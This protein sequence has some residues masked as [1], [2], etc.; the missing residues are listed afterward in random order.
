MLIMGNDD[1]TPNYSFF[2]CPGCE[3][4]IEYG[5]NDDIPVMCSHCRIL[6]PDMKDVAKSPQTRKI[7]HLDSKGEFF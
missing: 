5:I 4:R 2:V 7:Y 3:S 6:L 1:K